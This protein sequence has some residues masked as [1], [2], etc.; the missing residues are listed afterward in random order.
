MGAFQYKAMKSFI[1]PFGFFKAGLRAS[2][3]ATFAPVILGLSLMLAMPGRATVLL[4]FSFEEL[5]A[6][7]LLIVDAEVTGTETITEGD[8][9]RTRL[10]VKVNE[11]IKGAA[12]NETLVLDFLGGT[13]ANVTLEVSGQ[14][15]PEV[16]QSG[17]FFIN[18]PF[19]E[20]VNPLTGWYQGFFPVSVSADGEALLNLDARPDLVLANAGEDP[21]VRKLLD[22]GMTEQQVIARYPEYQ[23]FTVADFKAALA[24]IIRSQGD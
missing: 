8:Q 17:I 7:S 9:I 4:N 2:R 14:F 3:L 11:T 21:R 15:I 6:R 10:T 12:Q 20:Q 18:D 19:S 24:D 22:L 13:A 23:R 5:V 16:G 1:N